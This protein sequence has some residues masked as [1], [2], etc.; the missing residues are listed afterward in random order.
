MLFV[1]PERKKKLM[2]VHVTLTVENRKE[3]EAKGQQIVA[4]MM[5]EEHVQA[6]EQA[7]MDGLAQRVR[8]RMIK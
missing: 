3:W 2:F 1:G 8:D 7:E 5:E 6:M 4:D